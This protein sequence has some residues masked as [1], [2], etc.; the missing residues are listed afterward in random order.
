MQERE[1]YFVQ[2]LEIKLEYDSG[3]F[4][5]PPGAV[6]YVSFRATDNAGEL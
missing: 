6:S 3:D 4:A 5:M 2:W 1:N